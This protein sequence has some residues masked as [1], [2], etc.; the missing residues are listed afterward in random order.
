MINFGDDVCGFRFHAQGS[1]MLAPKR[2]PEKT[3]QL[4]LHCHASPRGKRILEIGCGDGRLTW[5]Y[6]P[7]AG[8]HIGLDLDLTSLGQARR[9]R[10]VA[11]SI[12]VDFAAAQAGALPFAHQSFDLVLFSWSL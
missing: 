2:D 12:R 4:Y 7:E 8:Y 1:I 6:A 11:M 9:N 10:P 5:R 3:E